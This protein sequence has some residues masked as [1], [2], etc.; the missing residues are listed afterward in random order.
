MW[1]NLKVREKRKGKAIVEKVK[2]FQPKTALHLPVLLQFY[3]GQVRATT[4][5]K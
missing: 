5:H 3:P 2:T 1:V 4:P